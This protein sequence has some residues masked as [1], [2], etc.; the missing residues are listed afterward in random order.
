MVVRRFFSV[1]YRWWVVAAAGCVVGAYLAAF[2][3]G[4]LTWSPSGIRLVLFAALGGALAVFYERYSGRILQRLSGQAQAGPDLASFIPAFALLV[5]PLFIPRFSQSLHSYFSGYVEH[6][7]PKVFLFGSILAGH[8]F[9]KLSRI[10]PLSHNIDRF[11]DTHWRLLLSSVVALYLGFFLTTGLWDFYIFGNWHDLSRFTTAQY[12]VLKGHF[13]LSRL[14]TESASKICEFVGDHFAPIKLVILPFFLIFRTAAVFLVFKTVAMGLGAIAFFLL[15]RTRLSALESLLLTLAYLLLPTAVAQNYTGFHPVCFATLLL[16]L[17]LFFFER[18]RFGWFVVLMVLCSGMKENVPFLM[19]LLGG[20]AILERRRV[21]WAATAVA[22]N[23]VWLAVVFGIL[24]PHFRPP[25]NTMVVRYPYIRSISALLVEVLRNP[26]IVVAQMCHPQ[27]Q[28]YLFL[29][30]APFLFLLPFGSVISTLGLVPTF[31]IA[32]LMNWEVPITFHHGIIPSA[33]FAAATAF[34]IARIARRTNRTASIGL[35]V[36]LLLVACFL[37]PVWW[38][39]FKMKPDGYWRFQKEA[40]ACVPPDVPATAPR[41]MLPHLA[42]RNEVF[43]LN[44]RALQPTDGAKYVIV[45]TQ[46]ICTPWE[47]PVIEE[48]RRTGRLRGFRLIWHKGPIYVFVRAEPG[49]P[50]GR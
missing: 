42:S 19:L 1:S 16:P 43:F 27:K 18:R 44:R 11:V 4:I 24:F 33:F 48:V 8:L 40:L 12:S 45:D 38:G 17:T 2:F 47:T 21:K 46:R 41:Y 15:A 10:K 23:A 39:A 9:I 26:S 3:P 49:A 5:I 7:G 34:T 22:V 14:H 37:V 29:L 13:F 35:S 36:S 32:A 30:M 6:L 28:Q 20:L 31:V 50:A 25:D